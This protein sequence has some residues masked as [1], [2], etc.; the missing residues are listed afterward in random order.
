MPK[1]PEIGGIFQYEGRAFRLTDHVTAED[2]T[3]RAVAEC[4]E[5]GSDEGAWWVFD[6]DDFVTRKHQ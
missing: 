4:L 6:C 1:G 5:P 3:E 2:G